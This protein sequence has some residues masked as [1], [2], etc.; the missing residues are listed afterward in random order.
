MYENRS[1]IVTLVSLIDSSVA[2]EDE[3][4]NLGKSNYEAE[5]GGCLLWRLLTMACDFEL[6]MYCM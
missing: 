1:Y 2:R 3:K 6:K 5:S 4:V